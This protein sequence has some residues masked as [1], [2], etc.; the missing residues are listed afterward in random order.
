MG[1]NKIRLTKKAIDY[2]SPY[3]NDWIVY[4]NEMTYSQDYVIHYLR[5]S[6]FVKRSKEKGVCVDQA[7]DS[8]L[9]L[10]QNWTP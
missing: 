8:V 5:Q 10:M 3:R 2:I 1:R 9:K 6:V 7:T 4:A